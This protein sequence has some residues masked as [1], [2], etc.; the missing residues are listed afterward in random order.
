M[1]N[2]NNNNENASE[3]RHI[4]R[5]NKSKMPIRNTIII[6]SVCIA[7]IFISTPIIINAYINYAKL[8][9][10]VEPV[11]KKEIVYVP[12]EPV[13]IPSIEIKPAVIT[14]ITNTQKL[15]VLSVDLNKDILID[16][17]FKL[18]WG[19]FKK[20]QVVTLNATIRYTTDLQLFTRDDIAF[21]MDTQRLM[22]LIPRPVID[23]ITINEDKNEIHDVKNGLL[24]FKNLE[25]TPEAYNEILVQGKN[26]I[27]YELLLDAEMQSKAETAAM[28][29]FN[30]LLVELF[31]E[32]TDMDFEI[33]VGFKETYK[34]PV[35]L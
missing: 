17:S 32:N 34:Y 33:I 25:L 21:D 16:D 23:S 7:I 15:Q 5:E 31:A 22:A 19:I 13:A 29:A 27:Q 11:V 28:E 35:N 12:A 6:L 1:D 24:R 8:K 10:P 20:Q 18:N 30:D 26:N 14:N 9:L 4:Y 2:E 3:K